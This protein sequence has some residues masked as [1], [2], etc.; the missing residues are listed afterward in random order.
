MSTFLNRITMTWP[1]FG[2]VAFWGQFVFLAI[3]LVVLVTAMFR[4]PRVNLAELDEDAE[5]DEEESLLAATGRRFTASWD[6]ARNN[7][8]NNNGSSNNRNYGTS[9]A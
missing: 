9:N 2:I 7:N 8:G 1:F 5:E 3:F 4:T 6:D